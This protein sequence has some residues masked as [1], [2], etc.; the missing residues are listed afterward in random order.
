MLVTRAVLF[1]LVCVISVC[2]APARSAD[3]PRLSEVDHLAP[4]VER[5]RGLAEDI[6]IRG[7][8][9]ALVRDGRLYAAEGFGPRDATGDTTVDADTMFYIASITKTY[10]AAAVLLLIVL[11]LVRQMREAALAAL[12][13]DPLGDRPRNGTIIRDPDNETFFAVKQTHQLL[14]TG[15]TSVSIRTR[16]ARLAS[17]MKVSNGVKM[18]SVDPRVDID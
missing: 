8:A 18:I 12:L 17:R 1:A 5:W 14:L 10:T 16:I 15:R 3:V 6:G 2:A 9:I 7:Y 4:L 11:G 13:H